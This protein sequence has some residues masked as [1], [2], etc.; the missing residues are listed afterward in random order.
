MTNQGR[1]HPCDE[2]T[3]LETRAT[4]EPRN[5]LPSTRPRDTAAAAAAG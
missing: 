5:D 1:I 4:D 2:R 3:P